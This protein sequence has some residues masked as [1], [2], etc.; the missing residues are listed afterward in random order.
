LAE[1]GI[2]ALGALT[3][4]LDLEGPPL[5]GFVDRFSQ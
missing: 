2:E 1:C 4:A 5:V 3:L